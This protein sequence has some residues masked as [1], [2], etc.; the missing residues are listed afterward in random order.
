MTHYRIT[1]PLDYYEATGEQ[2]RGALLVAGWSVKVIAAAI[3]V[4]PTTVYGVI[5]KQH[6]SM[7]VRRIIVHLCNGGAIEDAP[8]FNEL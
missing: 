5:N 8:A 7:R 2:I 4:A 1:P 6:G 3:G